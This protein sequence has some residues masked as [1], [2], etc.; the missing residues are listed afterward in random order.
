MQSEQISNRKL[1]PGLSDALPV[2][3]AN[4]LNF[5]ELGK[6]KI[7]TSPKT[8]EKTKK[9]N[10]SLTCRR[11]ETSCL[12]QRLAAHHSSLD[13]P[14]LS[15]LEIKKTTAQQSKSGRREMH[16]LENQRWVWKYLFCREKMGVGDLRPSSNSRSPGVHARPS[17]LGLPMRP[18]HR[19]LAAGGS[20]LLPGAHF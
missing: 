12:S 8:K 1:K 13:C 18:S 14:L 20:N 2:C 19:G 3:K 11:R 17:H 15:G 4:R 9:Q 10:A 5:A 7:K 6:E 16:W